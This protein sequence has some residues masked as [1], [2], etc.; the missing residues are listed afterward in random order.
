MAAVA[1]DET[2]GGRDERRPRGA[3]RRAPA[4]RLLAPV[5]VA[6][7]PA[8]VAGG[9]VRGRRP[10]AAAVA[11]VGLLVLGSWLADAVAP[12]SVAPV[13][14]SIPRQGL[15]STTASYIVQPGD[16][17]WFIA[18]ALARPGD[19]RDRVDA[20]ELANGGRLLRAGDRLAISVPD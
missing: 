8:P 10:L 20:L 7:A 11:V 19:I 16:T 17:Y 13:S 14:A 9:A 6:D 15:A 1:H 2:D 3:E 5:A 18:E 4:L 12:G